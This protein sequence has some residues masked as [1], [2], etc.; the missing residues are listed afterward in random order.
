MCI[1]MV[2]KQHPCQIS[3]HPS[4][5][6]LTTTGKQFNISRSHR[7]L[8]KQGEIGF[9]CSYVTLEKH[10]RTCRGQSGGVTGERST[11]IP[12]RNDF[13]DWICRRGESFCR[14]CV[15]VFTPSGAG[16]SPPPGLWGNYGGIMTRVTV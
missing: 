16:V 13:L 5:R 8:Q 11:A 3:G 4:Q 1:Q 12:G 15:S 7:A 9:L 2:I 6:F 14:V 10:R